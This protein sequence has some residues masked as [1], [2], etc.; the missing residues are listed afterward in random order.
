MKYFYFVS[1]S[2]V[3]CVGHMTMDSPLKVVCP[4]SFDLF[5]SRLQAE[6]KVSYPTIDVSKLVITSMS[7]LHEEEA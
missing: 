2:T 1:W 7:L 4:K 6:C 5:Y 3:K